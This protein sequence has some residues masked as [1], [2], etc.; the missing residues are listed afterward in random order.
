MTVLFCLGLEVY[1]Y[2][3]APAS[4]IEVSAEM[5]CVDNISFSVVD[6]FEDDH[7]I[8]VY[9]P[10]YLDEQKVHLPIS[11]D[12][13]LLKEFSFTSWQPPKSS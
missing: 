7:V 10:F 11:N 13:F 12:S 9:E 3:N 5:D 6:S 4:Y 1:S 2:Y 8:Q